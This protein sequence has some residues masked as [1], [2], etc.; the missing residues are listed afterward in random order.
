MLS[1]KLVDLARSIDKAR[2]RNLN[3]HQYQLGIAYAAHAI[4][5]DNCTGQERY[6]FLLACGVPFTL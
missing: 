2:W 1:R 3:D 6:H 4:A 5:D